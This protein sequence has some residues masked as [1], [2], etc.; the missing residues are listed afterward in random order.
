MSILSITHHGW[1]WVWA[2]CII[3][4]Q[5]SRGGSS[6]GQHTRRKSLPA[7][8][9]FRGWL[10]TKPKS[11]FTRLNGELQYFSESWL[12]WELYQRAICGS[13]SFSCPLG[14]VF[15]PL[16]QCDGFWNTR[17]MCRK[18]PW[19]IQR[20]HFIFLW[21]RCPCFLLR[22]QF[23]NWLHHS[24]TMCWGE[25]LQNACVNATHVAF[26]CIS[27]VAT[28]LP[29]WG[30][31]N[32]RNEARTAKVRKKALPVFFEKYNLLERMFQWV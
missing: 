29:W 14:H 12:G 2:G 3:H 20:T 27:Q 17:S 18:D 21:S 10:R 16:L 15:L 5:K 7:I 31:R 24:S 19:V 9:S 30:T 26:F 8:L 25:E 11:V 1:P 28:G 32:S 4:S 13:Q 6:L 22:D 23:S